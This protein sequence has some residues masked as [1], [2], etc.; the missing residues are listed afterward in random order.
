MRMA[1]VRAENAVIPSPPGLPVV[2]HLHQIA[3][4]GLISH[5]LRV[6]R[7]F[8]EGIFK[9]RFGSRVGLFVTGADL[10]AELSDETRFRKMPGPGL[11]VVRRFA[12]DGLFTAFSDEPNWGKAHRILLPAFSQRAM[13]G[14]FDMILEVCDQLVAKW[15]RLSGTDVLVA[16]D[17][18][19]LTL[20]SIAIAGFGH[21]FDS[22][23][24]DE[25]DSFLVALGSALGESL[26]MITRLPLQNRFARRAQRRFD[27]DIAEMNALVDGIIADRRKNPTDGKDLLN[28]MI[29]AVDPETGERLDDVNIRYQVLTFLIAGH[30]TTS[31]ML[32]FAFHHLLRTPHVLA[33]AYAE[34]D[35]VLPGDTRPDYA[36]VAQLEVIERIL[37]EALRLWPT[38]P[39][40]SV[41]PFE[42]TLIGGKWA[43][44]KDRPINIFSPGLHRDPHVWDD[45]EEFDIDRWLPEA[46][47]A[48]HPHAYKPFGNGARACIG[49]QFAMVEAKIAMAMMLRAFAVS[50][51]H[52]YRLRIK[53]TLSIKP[54]DFHMRIRLR[55]PH[56]RL[57]VAPAAPLGEDKPVAAVSGTGQRFAVIY[58]SSLGTARD[59]AEEIA[60]RAAVDGFETVVRSM[61]ESF[62]GG[63]KPE[64]K[65]VVIV[66]ATYNGRAPDSAIEVERALDA[67]LFEDAD[68]RGARVAVLGVGNSPWPNYQVFP[69][70]IAAAVETAGATM[71][72][73]RAE[74]DGQG[75]FDGAVAGFVRDLW[76]GLGREAMPSEATSSLSLR[77]VDV[78]AARA[79]ALPEHAQRLEIVANDELVRPA[80]GLWDFAIEPP[81][82]STRLIRIRLP[83]GQRYHSG[84]HIAVY[85]RNRPDLVDRA[86]AR[87]DL[88]G[89]TQLRVEGQGGRFKH[90]PLGQTV[91][92]RQLLTDFV[93][94]SDTLPRRALAVIAAQTRCPNTRAELARLDGDAFEAEVVGKRLSVLDLLERHPAAELSLDGFVEL[95]AAIAPRFYSIASSPLADPHVADLI[96]GTM[97][98]P[99]WSG[100][101]EHRGF[102]SGY[103]QGVAVGDH[104][105]GYVRRPNP[106][107]APPADATV[108]MIL[109]GPGTGFAPLRGFLQERAAQ[110]AAGDDVAQSLLFFGCRHPDHDWF[111][112]DEVEEW[113]AQGVIKPYLAFSALASHPW[114]FVQDALWAE[115][116]TVWAAINTGA[117]IYLCGDGKF[118][119]PAV[120]DTLIR[121][122]MQQ[123]GDEHA[124]GSAWLETMMAEGRFHQDVFGFG[125]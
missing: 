6:A 68:W 44:R 87:L 103:M 21:R 104:V 95:S 14:Y 11:R 85:A 20:D 35:R 100:L 9:L 62:K 19:R 7:D 116:E 24:K 2:G 93:E 110:A 23:E 125:K 76:K 39:A 60:E 36:H 118:M 37:K 79:Q 29:A 16:D 28:L 54:D 109:I 67:G 61:D 52:N 102:A 8:P 71:L 13:R 63:A 17:M 57:S 53:E 113:A 18:T 86:M 88:K 105:F 50:D 94:L 123:V 108:P 96:V 115:Q 120:R 99:A 59:I 74:A 66:T 77:P 10:V 51:P 101:G 27:A 25:L 38:A 46:E 26:N 48:R 73:P 40:F 41:A 33:Q 1:T 111:C 80:D 12:G 34:V 5:L 3:R 69:K 4:Y 114:K 78:D 112:R 72:L 91:T 31:G 90:L 30:E 92:V 58:G 15:T 81:R 42:D 117:H 106:P 55:S 49:R 84:D 64:D 43:M 89:A 70:R 45:P 119:A 124:Q 65:V 121:I 98:A 97:A 22:F 56:E 107:F 47:A 75:D 82:P 122:Q 32:T 83:E